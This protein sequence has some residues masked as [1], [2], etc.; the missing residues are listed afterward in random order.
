VQDLPHRIIF[1]PGIVLDCTEAIAALQLV[2]ICNS[3]SDRAQQTFSTERIYLTQVR[4]YQDADLHYFSYSTQP[5]YPGGSTRQSLSASAKLLGDQ[6][7][8]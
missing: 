7:R 4:G 3:P 5:S 6:I 2:D 8:Q 1:I